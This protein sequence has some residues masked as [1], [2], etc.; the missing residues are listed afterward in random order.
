MKDQLENDLIVALASLIPNDR[1]QD[2]KMR[3]TMAVSKYDV[4]LAETALTVWEGDKNELIFRRFFAA[5]LAKGL[6]KKT[7]GYYRHTLNW[8]F[9]TIEKN[10]DEVTADDIRLYLAT[11]VQR[12]GVSKATANNERRNLSSFYGW[13]QT[14]EILLHNPMNKID[15]IK[16]TKKKKKAYSLLDL[17]KIRTGCRTSREKA[18]VEVLASTWCRVTELLEMKIS[19]IEGDKLEVHGKGDKYRTVY[20]NA[21]AQIA[22]QG[23]LSE[24]KDNSPY[25][26]PGCR[27]TATS[28]EFK[29]LLYARGLT[30][31]EERGLW[32][33]IPELVDDR[34]LGDPSRIES[35]VRTI[36]ARAGVDKVHP[37]RFRRTG[38]TMALRQGMPITTVQKLLG[39]ESLETTQIYLDVSDEDIEQAHRRYV[40]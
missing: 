23:Y 27:Y 2:A 15:A 1:V 21:R 5:K 6:S 34:S 33:T 36:G 8:F 40:V 12:D 22:L 3:I 17:E 10:Y 37:H 29:D 35:V 13:L 11:R 16:E 26:F 31:L 19:D 14:E 9:H 39:H 24:R 28:R 18:I 32:Y 38:A 30:S 20:L 7:L 25:L 4:T